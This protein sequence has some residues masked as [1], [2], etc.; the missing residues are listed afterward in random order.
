V[1]VALAVVARRLSAGTQWTL[2]PARSAVVQIGVEIDAAGFARGETGGANAGTARA[3][4]PGRAGMV[5]GAAVLAVG[6]ET[7]AVPVAAALAVFAGMTATAAVAFV[8]R[9]VDA[10][11]VASV[12]PVWANALAG[13][14]YSERCLADAIAEVGGVSRRGLIRKELAADAGLAGVAAVVTAGL[15]RRAARLLDANLPLRTRAATRRARRCRA[16][17]TPGEDAGD[18]NGNQADER[19]T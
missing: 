1:A 19:S 2:V 13:A 4:H 17:F 7:D 18:A 15:R 10:R 6:R 12:P 3:R 16:E 8:G 11:A 14:V 9:D 5:A